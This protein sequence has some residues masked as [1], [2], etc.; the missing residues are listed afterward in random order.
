V[1]GE[2]DTK[3]YI[4]I[5]GLPGYDPNSPTVYPPVNVPGGPYKE[6]PVEH[7]LLLQLLPLLQPL[8]LQFLERLLKKHKHV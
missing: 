8:L 4:N 6:F 5:P 1:P 3:P 2:D 7:R